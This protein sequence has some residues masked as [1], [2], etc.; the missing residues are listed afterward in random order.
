MNIVP[1]TYQYDDEGHIVAGNRYSESKQ[2]SM[3]Q[4]IRD[5][6]SKH[7]EIKNELKIKRSLVK[8]ALEQDADYYKANEA[9]KEYQRHRTAVKQRLMKENESLRKMDEETKVLKEELKSVQLSLEDYI[10]EY[11]KNTGMQ[12]IQDNEGVLRRIH[13]GKTAKVI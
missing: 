9:V 4:K 1:S 12:T 10:I 8:R 5:G 11:E 6:L 2:E 13:I 7:K 3:E